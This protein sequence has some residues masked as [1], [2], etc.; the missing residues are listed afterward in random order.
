MA[1]K[2]VPVLIIA[3]LA[4]GRAFAQTDFA[5]MPKNT[6]TVDF[7]P[8]II[9][10]AIGMESMAEDIDIRTSGFWHCGAI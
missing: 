8:T 6:I 4:A 7:G 10:A 9:G 2:I 3:A 1:K 5:T